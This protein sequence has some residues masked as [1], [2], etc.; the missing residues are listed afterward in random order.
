[1][2]SIYIGTILLLN[3]PYIQQRMSVLVADE[4]SEV[5]QAKLTIGRIDIGLL[6][7]IIVDDLMLEDRS[8]GDMLK[9][10]RLS[11]KFDILP[12]FEGKISIGTVQLFG[13][14]IN[15]HKPTPLD[16]P[17]FRFVLD[18]FAPKD[19]LRR[20]SPLDLRINSILIRRG[21]LSYDVLSERHTPG[22]FNSGHIALR[23]IIANISLK[24]LRNDS[25]NVAVK[26]MSMQEEHSGFTLER[27]NFKLVGNTRGLRVEDFAIGLPHSTLRMDTIRV[28]CDSL[29]RL[30]DRAG[31]VHVS[32]R[33][34]PSNVV[35]S[36][37]SAFVPAFAGFDDAIRME[38]EAGG[39]L[40]QLDCSRIV[41]YSQDRHFRLNGNISLQELSRPSDIYLY[42]NLSNLYADEEGIAF[43]VRNLGP[44]ESDVPLPLARLGSVSF[45]GQVSGYFTDLVMYGRIRTGL[46]DVDTDLKL[47]SDREQ[48]LFS[49]SGMITT[50]NFGLGKM[51]GNDKLGNVTLNVDVDGGLRKG[52]AP[53]I[54]C[55]GL[56]KALDYSGYT[57]HNISLDGEY[58]QDGFNGKV[59]LDDANGSFTLN[60]VVN[61]TGQTPTFNFLASI[62]RFRPHDLNLT[63]KYE[64]AEFSV[65]VKADFTG[66]TI[67]EMNG[68]INIDS[69]LYV[70][71]GQRHFLNNIKVVASRDAEAHQR[72]VLTSEF[73]EGTIEGHYLY[74]TLPAG[75]LNIAR[76]YVPTLVPLLGKE[77]QTDNDFRFNIHI[78]NTELLSDMFK[79]PLT[80]Y[81]H[82]TLAGAFH[83]KAGKMRIEGYFPRLR[84]E[85]K[86]IESAMVLC[87]TSGD[88][89][90]AL[91][92]LT[93]R[94]GGG[95]INVSVE[96]Y[97]HDDQV[98]TA[99][100]WGNNGAVTY[101]GRLAAMA[102]FIRQEAIPDS[103]ATHKQKRAHRRKHTLPPLKTVVDIAHTDVIVN[104]T[105]WEIHPSQVVIDSGKV[106]IDNFYFSHDD[107]HL[108]I[109]GTLSKLPEDTVHVDL[110][111][112]NIGYVFDIADLG[113]NF[114]GEATGP[115]YAY[116]VLGG[117]PVMATDLHIRGFGLNDGLLGDADIRGEWH[118]QVKG[119]YLDARIREKDIARTHVQGYIYPIKPNGSLDLHIDADNTNLRFIHYFMQ[120][121][122]SD[123]SG[124][125][126]G[127]IHFY[128]RFKALAM[129]GKVAGDASMKVDVLNTT[130]NIKD[131]IF[132]APDGLTFRNNRIYD[133]QGHEGR[134]SG[135]LR[136]QHFK[137][138]EYRFNFNVNNMLVMNT[139]ESPDFPFYGT[140]YATGSATI[141][142]NEHDGVNIDV[143]MTTNRNSSF[144]YIKDQVTSAVSN[145]FIRFVDKTPRRAIRDTLLLSA[146]ERD[147]QELETAQEASA[148][149][150]L[151]LAIEATSDATMRIIMDPAAGD[152]ISGRGSGNI[153]TEFYNKGDVKMF[154]N[155][156]ID[157]G[158]YKFSLQEVI[159]KDFTIDEGST[160]S[161]NGA[162]LDATLNID[163][164]YTVN[165]VSLNDLMPNAGM[166]GLDQTNIK[167]DCLMN[168]SGQLTSPEI[169]MDLEFPNERDE[170]QTIVRS[171]IT[172]DEEMSMQ[173]LYLLGIGKFYASE[174]AG[175]T[176]N[177][178]VMSSVLSSTL[179]GQLSNALSNIIDNNNWNVGTNLS[180]GERGWTDVEFEGML[181]G[182][183]L[184]NRLLING[185]FG[186]RDN[187]L[188]NTNFVGDFEAEWLVNR[189]GTIRLKAYNE[190]NDRYYTR[191][192]LTTQ[193][194]GIIFKKDFNR[195][196]ELLFWNR[197]KLRRL[198]QRLEA[199][200]SDK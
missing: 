40:D 95:A 76:R 193:G 167:V 189:S 72:L 69:L 152:Y 116:G 52:K 136:Y 33:M 174:S 178:D 187:P 137:H 175:G 31:D 23:N 165:S 18:A 142:G 19:T 149:I 44:K 13:F 28:Q 4:L 25:I 53:S 86:F 135:Y 34:L 70:A 191:T 17:N 117:N 48:G 122:T 102:Q 169:K 61:T 123:F 24:A 140:V 160:I 186:Y 124:R 67:D 150:H 166:L 111:D 68:E 100:N 103:I 78:Y 5:L 75:I 41:L 195:W 112:I 139:K 92:R 170:V 90:H 36:D 181:S 130:Y 14:D 89:L 42:G 138:L 154:G 1:M 56:V 109:H 11:A 182:Q 105:L 161:F 16:E 47:S 141:A 114:K 134:V 2:L 10:A 80:V 82:S 128:G 50:S 127:K 29:E 97:A 148:D 192:N 198:K 46:G 37:V 9:V 101:S 99:L 63:S 60:G 162:P 118:H 194:I 27:L 113:V 62:E 172:T 146:Y 115:A 15:L 158:I 143:G 177:S 26:R 125:A 58:G 159:R 54:I 106:H 87:E 6:N 57:Y 83:D 108:R 156:R 71:S 144:T 22:Q 64:D 197:W 185:N 73:V 180:T 55:K 65:K 171:Y 104:D 110:Q 200:E 45:Q 81:T 51:L 179:S 173:I 119:I 79:L 183:L 30:K 126:K 21:R 190:T 145:Q 155:Y 32:F 59:A 196:S 120:N 168:L 133:S 94:K 74:R 35:L 3:I 85:E 151:N 164:R 77:K 39:T 43:F 20:K 66:G 91:A 93:N 199:K 49:Y 38:M 147:R 121:I 131:S 96:A 107:R 98:Q 12:L 84:Y 129:E 163:A 176:Q 88:K 7:R 8:G 132:I 188:S 153:R 184:N 157:Q